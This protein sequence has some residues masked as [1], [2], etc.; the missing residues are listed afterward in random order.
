[1]SDHELLQQI[2]RQVYTVYSFTQMIVFFGLV[3]FVA[4][5]LWITFHNR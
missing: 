4:A 3:G 1:M 5:V 2:A